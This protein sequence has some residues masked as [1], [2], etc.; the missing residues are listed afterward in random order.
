M[1][2]F[3][4]GIY[5]FYWH[6]KQ[7]VAFKRRSGQPI[8]PIARTV[9]AGITFFRLVKE[10]RDASVSAGLRGPVGGGLLGFSYLL[11]GI[12]AWRLPEPHCF[13]AGLAAV[14][15]LLSAQRAINRLGAALG[16][17]DRPNAWLSVLNI[18]SILV[19]WLLL[20][21]IGVLFFP[22]EGSPVE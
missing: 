12:G 7:W 22:A 20:G 10:I 6:Y 18:V 11:L 3:T 1:S 4:F 9:F 2:I 21:V 14:V 15:P 5:E 17:I 13:L 19:V 16:T 8:W